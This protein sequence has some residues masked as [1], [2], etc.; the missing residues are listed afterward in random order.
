MSVLQLPTLAVLL[1]PERTHPTNQTRRAVRTLLGIDPSPGALFTDG[2]A[3]VAADP[4]SRA[5]NSR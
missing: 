4:R 1:H 3:P 5:S 2:E